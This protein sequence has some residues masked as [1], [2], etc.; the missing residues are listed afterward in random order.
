MGHEVPG[1]RGIYTHIPPEWRTDLMSGLQL[2]ASRASEDCPFLCGAAGRSAS[3]SLEACP[4]QN[5]RAA[6]SKSSASALTR[7]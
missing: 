4:S 3:D 1:T 2:P 5:R 6:V 7:S